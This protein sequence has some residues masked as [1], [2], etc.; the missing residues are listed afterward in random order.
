VKDD[1]TID[2]LCRRTKGVIEREVDVVRDQLLRNHVHVVHGNAR[3]VDSHTVH[4]SGGDESRMSA[5]NIVIATG[6]RPAHPPDVEFDD[7]TI[8]DSDGLLL[9]DRIPSSVVVVGA[10]VVGIEYA[11]MFAALGAKVTVVEARPL[12]D[13]ARADHRGP[14][15]PPARLGVVFAG[16]EVTASSAHDGALR[17]SQ[18]QR[19]P[20]SSWPPRSPGET[21]DAELE[22]GLQADER[23]RSPSADYRTAVSISSPATCRQPAS[24]HRDGAASASARAGTTLDERVARSGSTIRDLV[25]RTEEELTNQPCPT[26]SDLSYRELARGQI[27]S[28]T[29]GC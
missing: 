2:D 8:L 25:S 22:R 26:R 15:V 4:L 19:V 16:E 17:A 12:L 7:R 10:G 3:F 27:L 29:Q 21:E 5:E 11:S 23:G 24:R 14:A 9:L 28:D 13:S 1:I 6:T 18:R 20:R